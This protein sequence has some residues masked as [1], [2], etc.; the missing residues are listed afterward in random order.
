MI[1]G[2]LMNLTRKEDLS[3]VDRF[4]FEIL[5]P[6][7]K[8]LHGKNDSVFF[9]KKADAAKDTYF[10]IRKKVTMAPE[11][12]EVTGCNSPEDLK[13]GLI[14]L[15]MTEGYT[16]LPIMADAIVELAES[17]HFSEEES[18]EVSPFIY[19]MF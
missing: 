14:S 2:K 4:F 15:W 19:V 3:K 6:L 18:S 1:G 13:N 11:D 9:L 7:A 17:A 12:F 5:I 8:E 16:A 10:R